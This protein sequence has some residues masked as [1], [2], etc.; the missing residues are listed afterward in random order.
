MIFT[1]YTAKKQPF[2]PSDD[3]TRSWWIN[4]RLLMKHYFVGGWME[5][6]PGSWLLVLVHSQALSGFQQGGVG[7]G[8]T[9]SIHFWW[10]ALKIKVLFASW[11]EVEVVV[12]PLPRTGFLWSW[13]MKL[14]L[15][16]ALF[17]G[18]NTVYIFCFSTF[19]PQYSAYIV[20]L[21]PSVEISLVHIRRCLSESVWVCVGRLFL[22][23][24]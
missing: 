17:H 1:P 15:H 19:L 14:M 12:P 18:L 10:L 23:L 3:V 21:K 9:P 13:G 22:S 6:L 5:T 16:V 2:I 20:V 4:D 7:A 24:D 11:S 8:T